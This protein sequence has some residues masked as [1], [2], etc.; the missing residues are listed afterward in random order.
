MNWKLDDNDLE[1]WRANPVTEWILDLLQQRAR[2]SRETILEQFWSGV[3]VSPAELARG[4]EQEEVTRDLM[5]SSAEDFNETKE[6]L[7]EYERNRAG[8]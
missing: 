1:S 4:Q 2:L 7:D 6:A 5:E 8:Q 3:E